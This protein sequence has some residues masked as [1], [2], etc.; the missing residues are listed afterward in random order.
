LLVQ[1]KLSLWR[2]DSGVVLVNEPEAK[3]WPQNDQMG[4]DF[5][6]DLGYIV[7]SQ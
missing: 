1:Y 7:L 6:V 4:G 3:Q 5:S 2:P